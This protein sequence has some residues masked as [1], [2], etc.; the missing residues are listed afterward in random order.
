MFD[1]VVAVS[2]IC[3]AAEK[4]SDHSY[5]RV[6]TTALPPYIGEASVLLVIQQMVCGEN[7]R[8]GVLKPLQSGS[9]G[10]RSGVALLW[11]SLYTLAV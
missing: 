3:K 7:C 10:R 1:I 6:V 11:P 9:R 5:S 4:G 2:R 8:R